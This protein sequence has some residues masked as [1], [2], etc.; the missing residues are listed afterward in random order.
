MYCSLL[1][2]GGYFE[3]TPSIN[4]IYDYEQVQRKEKIHSSYEESDMRQNT[5]NVTQHYKVGTPIKTLYDRKEGVLGT[6]SLPKNSLHGGK[7]D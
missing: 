4:S 3:E 2:I 5:E 1:F 7:N 6:L